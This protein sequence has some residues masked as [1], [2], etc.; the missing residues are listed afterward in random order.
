MEFHFRRHFRLRPKMKN[1][2][3]SASSIHHKKILVLVLVLVLRCKVL[4]WSWSWTLGLVLILVLVLKKVL[5]TSLNFSV[6]PVGKTMRWIE[7]MNYT[8]FDG[9]DELYAK[10]GDDPGDDRTTR[11]G[12]RCENVVF[13]TMFFDCHAPSPERRAFEGCISSTKHCVAIYRQIWT[14]FTAFFYKWLLFQMHY[15]VRIFVA[16]WRHNFGEIA[17]K[18]CE[19]SKN[20]RESLCAPLRVVRWEF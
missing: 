6:H 3:R 12:C 11:A 4:Q 20:R 9:L 13:V 2:F 5:I 7:K 16:R 8:F 19:K 1:A 17:A 18:N 15:I 14:R 10:F